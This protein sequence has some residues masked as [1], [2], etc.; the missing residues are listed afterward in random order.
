MSKL[1]NNIRS[2]QNKVDLNVI[3]LSLR[4]A[5]PPTLQDI[6]TTDVEGNP[7]S[8]QATQLT[9]WTGYSRAVNIEEIDFIR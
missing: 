6:N 9:G 2:R 4:K 1:L 7:V 3:V 8:Q 5:A